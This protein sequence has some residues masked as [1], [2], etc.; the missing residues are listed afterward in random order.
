MK[1]STKPPPQIKSNKTDATGVCANAQAVM[2]NLKRKHADRYISIRYHRRK[3]ISAYNS[4]TAIRMLIGCSTWCY[5]LAASSLDSCVVVSAS[6]A[7]SRLGI[8]PLSLAG[9]RP[10]VPSK[11]QG[12]ALF[13][14]VM[15]P[16]VPL[17]GGEGVPFSRK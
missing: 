13:L 6:A 16:S 9:R 2:G 8:S 1:R 12:P 5:R 4:I 11:T 14:G 3:T 15:S 17:P 7:E 10:A